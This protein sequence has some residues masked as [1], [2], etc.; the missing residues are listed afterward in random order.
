[1]AK[2]ETNRPTAGRGKMQEQ[3]TEPMIEQQEPIKKM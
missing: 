3:L 2:K 1:M